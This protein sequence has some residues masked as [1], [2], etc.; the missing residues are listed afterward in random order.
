MYC[1]KGA[2]LLGEYSDECK[3]YFDALREAY[4]LASRVLHGRNLKRKDREASASTVNIAQDLCRAAIQH[5]VREGSMPNWG[6]VA[7]GRGFRRGP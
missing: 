5:I 2:W 1:D 3:V 4:G 7:L 6:E